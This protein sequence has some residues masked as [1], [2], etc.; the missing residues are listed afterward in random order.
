[1]PMSIKK[2][3]LVGCGQ[4]GAGIVEISARAGYTVVAREVNQELADKGLARIGKSLDRAVSKGKLGEDERDAILGRITTT[5]SLDDLADCDLI[6]EAVVEQK[7]LKMEIFRE[8]DGICKPDAIF[9]TNTSSLVVTELA[10]A[11]NRQDRFA[12]L[13]FFNPVPVM[14]LVE[15]VRTILTSDETFD[16][17]FEFAKSVGKT[18]VAAVDNSGFIVNRLLI[19][20]LLDAIA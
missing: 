10:M 15:V 1:M 13:H 18:P 16:T 2:V 19:P 9:C 8:L 7:E 20:Y 14:K 4:M 17:I 5:T 12:C 3:G 11:T 6:I